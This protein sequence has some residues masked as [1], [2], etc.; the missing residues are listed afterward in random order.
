M[1][2]RRI[3]FRHRPCE[4]LHPDGDHLGSLDNPIMDDRKRTGTV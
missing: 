2:D 3:Y 1:D 4:I